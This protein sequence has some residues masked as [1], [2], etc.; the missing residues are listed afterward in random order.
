MFIQKLKNSLF[1]NQ[2]INNLFLLAFVLL[3]FVLSLN[4]TIIFLIL[5]IYLFYLFKRNKKLFKYV[6][7]LLIIF[8]LL[9]LIRKLIYYDQ[10]LSEFSG[11]IINIEK[12]EYYNKLIVRNHLFKVIIKDSNFSNVEIGDKVFVSGTNQ[13]LEHSQNE[14]EFDYYNY[15][16]SNNTISIIKSNNIIKESSIN[17]YLIRKYLYKYLDNNFDKNSI[18]Y[19]KGFIFGDQKE[20]DEETIKNISING[21]SHLFAISGLHIS[22]IITFLEKILNKTKIKNKEKIIIIFLIFYSIITYFLVS[23]MRA[24]IMYIIKVINEKYNL[25]LKSMDIFSLCFIGFLLFNPDLINNLS[26]QLSFGASFTIIIFSV[27]FKTNNLNSLISLLVTTLF[28]QIFMLPLTVNLNNSFNIL[29]PIT[30]VLFIS[31]V[32]YIVLPF[33][34]LSFF[35]PILNKPFSLMI[36]S[37]EYM[38]NFFS[39][40]VSLNIDLPNMSIIEGMVIYIL[41]L[42]VFYFIKRNK[43]NMKI[44]FGFLC[45]IISIYYNKANLNISGKVTFLNLV[46]GDSIIIDYPFDQGVVVI[47][48]GTG[49][50]ESVT[51]YLKST[52]IRKID[53]LVITHGHNDHNGEVKTILKEFKVANLIKNAYDINVYTQNDIKLQAGDKFSCGGSE[54]ICLNPSER[55]GTENDN[56]IVLFTKIGD[57][58]YLFLGDSSKEIENNLNINERVDVVKVGHHGSSTS[59]D[60]S[61]YQKIDPKYVIIETGRVKTYGFPSLKTIENLKDYKIYR[62]DINK[63]IYIL[64][65]NKIFNRLFSKNS[66]I[67]S[68][69]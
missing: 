59:T 46:E 61:F 38:N 32:S 26:F 60:K 4:A 25:K 69:A 48:T 58:K 43:K 63:E 1:Y 33:T 65:P 6:I 9:Y 20:I 31:L 23:I 28:V 12:K 55:N 18:A 10:K 13:I 66:N 16:I 34:F 40:Y 27:S 67:Y 62:T 15:L 49:V 68:I 44:C 30:N 2:F 50:N 56:S 47:D 29:S 21:I 24:V 54:F 41:V 39:K 64:F 52:G 42:L 7:C 3:L 51:N 45:M 35:I 8:L 19:I 53:Y 36:E 14:F 17:I 5:F 37:F 57:L 22:L 11:V